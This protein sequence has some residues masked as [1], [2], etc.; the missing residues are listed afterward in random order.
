MCV[1]KDGHILSGG[2]K[3]RKIYQWDTNYEKT[4]LEYEV[5]LFTIRGE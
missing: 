1:T 3:D 4:G 2:G 5:K